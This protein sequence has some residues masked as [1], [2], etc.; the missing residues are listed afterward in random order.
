MTPRVMVVP[1]MLG[2][3]VHD[4]GVNAFQ[5]LETRLSKSALSSPGLARIGR[6]PPQW[7]CGPA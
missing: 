6:E 7:N 3:M 4:D 2:K 5:R 1:G